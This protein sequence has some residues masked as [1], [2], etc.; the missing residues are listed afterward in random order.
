MDSELLKKADK[1]S[2]EHGGNKCKARG[3][4]V[5]EL[6]MCV[7]SSEESTKAPNAADR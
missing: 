5:D 7:R 3:F 6:L 4:M 2:E 1:E